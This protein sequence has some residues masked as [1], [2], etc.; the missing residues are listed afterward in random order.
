M[1]DGSIV[2]TIE[3]CA[4]CKFH[5]GST[6][7]DEEKYRRVSENLKISINRHFPNFIVFMKPNN[8]SVKEKNSFTTFI[9]TRIGACDV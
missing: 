5:G 2:I 3:Y 4:N 9:R 1:E 7:H 6:R 8:Y